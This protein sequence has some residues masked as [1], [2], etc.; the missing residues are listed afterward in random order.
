MGHKGPVLT[1]RCIKQQQQ[2]QISPS[3]YTIHSLTLLQFSATIRSHLQ[4]V[5]CFGKETGRRIIWK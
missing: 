3:N 1:P 2:Q 5:A 4:W